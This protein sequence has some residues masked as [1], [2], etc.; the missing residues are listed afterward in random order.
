[1]TADQRRLKRIKNMVYLLAALMMSLHSPTLDN[2]VATRLRLH[3]GEAA[4]LHRKLAQRGARAKKHLRKK[5]HNGKG[6]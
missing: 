5:A 4:E 2:W 3:Q 6:R 1:M